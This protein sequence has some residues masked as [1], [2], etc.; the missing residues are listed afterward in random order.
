[1]E[2]SS[3]TKNEQFVSIA[4]WT[5]KLVSRIKEALIL[6][7]VIVLQVYAHIISNW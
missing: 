1:M 5:L 6:I 4:T 2:Y 3:A 7:V